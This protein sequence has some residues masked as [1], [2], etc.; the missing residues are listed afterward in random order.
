MIP[1]INF[2]RSFGSN[3]SG[4]ATFGLRYYAQLRSKYKGVFNSSVVFPG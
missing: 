3:D 4:M 2:R 1:L